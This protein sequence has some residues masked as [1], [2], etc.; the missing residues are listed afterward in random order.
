[1][2]AICASRT[3]V[4][5]GAGV[6]IWGALVVAA[7]G[8]FAGAGA[9]VASIHVEG[10]VSEPVRAEVAANPDIIHVTVRPFRL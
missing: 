8:V 1:M 2:A 6:C 4:A 3:G 5:V 10:N 7:S 9:A